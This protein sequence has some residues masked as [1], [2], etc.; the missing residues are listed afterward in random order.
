MT[1]DLTEAEA[2]ALAEHLRRALA[3]DPF[4]LA[5][6]L[7]PLRA[8]LSKLDPAAEQPAPPRPRPPAEPSLIVRRNRTA[9]RR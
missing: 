5:P 1:L 9:R 7:R 2:K 6:R 8:V 3:D 4:P